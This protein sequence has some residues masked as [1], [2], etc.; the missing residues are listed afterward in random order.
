MTTPQFIASMSLQLAIPGRVGLHQSPLALR[1]PKLLCKKE[2]CLNRT[3]TK[4][5]TV[6]EKNCLTQ[7][8]HSIAAILLACSVVPDSGAFF[9]CTQE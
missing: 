3:L 6:V 1:Q 9:I 5:T 8:V 4:M 7:R 2:E